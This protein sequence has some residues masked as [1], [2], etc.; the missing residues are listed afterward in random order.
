MSGSS[1]KGAEVDE[2]LLTATG[3]DTADLRGVKCS[4]SVQGMLSSRYPGGSPDHIKLYD[5]WDGTGLS[6]QPH[7]P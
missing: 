3:L 4:A 2:A 1:F 6:L 5:K 7:P